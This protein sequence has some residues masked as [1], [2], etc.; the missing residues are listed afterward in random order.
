[1]T[2]RPLIDCDKP[3]RSAYRPKPREFAV[4]QTSCLRTHCPTCSCSTLRCRRAH[5]DCPAFQG[6]RR[7]W[8][9]KCAGARDR[10]AGDLE[11]ADRLRQAVKNPAY[12]PKPRSFRQA[13]SCLATHCPTCSCSNPAL[14]RAHAD[15]PAFKVVGGAARQRAAPRAVRPV[16]WTALIEAE[17]VLLFN[18]PR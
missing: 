12:R 6:R 5:A 8:L 9:V 4:R 15:R 18:V 1:V 14:P 13:D 11:A 16:I 7:C 2:W 3:L 10:A 17:S